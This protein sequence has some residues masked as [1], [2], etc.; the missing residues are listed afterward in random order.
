MP[1]NGRWP[2]RAGCSGWSSLDAIVSVHRPISLTVQPLELPWLNWHLPFMFDWLSENWN[3]HMW[4]VIAVLSAAAAAVFVFADRK[5]QKRARLDRVG[6]IPW[7]GLSV[8]AM[9]VTLISAVL[10]VKAG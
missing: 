7:T 3:F 5:R 6:F 10:A 8:L 4:A 9:G 1:S 2:D